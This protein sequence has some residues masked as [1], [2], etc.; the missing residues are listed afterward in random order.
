MI[1]NPH[2]RY[3]T[4]HLN[5]AIKVEAMVRNNK[6]RFNKD[7]DFL[8]PF[9]I[10]EVK[11]EIPGQI[12]LKVYKEQRQKEGKFL[13]PQFVCWNKLKNNLDFQEHQASFV[14]VVK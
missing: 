7:V 1:C 3:K 5:E 13:T 11:W 9:L 10:D 4:T 2:A 8:Q 12:T 6:D 14:N